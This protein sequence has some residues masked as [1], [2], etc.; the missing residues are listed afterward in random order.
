[1][2]PFSAQYMQFFEYYLFGN[3]FNLDEDIIEGDFG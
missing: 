1:M 2:S 3:S